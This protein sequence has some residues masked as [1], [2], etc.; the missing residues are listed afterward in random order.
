MKIKLETQRL[1]LIPFERNDLHLLYETFT[2][3]FVRKFLW[4]DEI[5]TVDQTSNILELN[6]SVFDSEGWGLWKIIV[7]NGQ[8]FAGFVGLWRFFDEGQPQLLFG[9][10]PAK[11]GL[12]Y[13]TEASAAIVDYA[14]NEL[15][16]TF[17]VASF[18]SPNVASEKVCRRLKMKKMEDRVINNKSTSFYR[19]EKDK[20]IF[21]GDLTVER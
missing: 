15:G 16:Y 19:I 2:N 9:L 8:A 14:F 13:A 3:H 1:S 10:M 5:I 6:E 18:D 12:G 4:D 11:T 20:R 21:S 7:K 17:I